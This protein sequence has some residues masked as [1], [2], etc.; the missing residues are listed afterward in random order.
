M[1]TKIRLMQIV[2][3]F[4]L[5]ALMLNVG[6]P[7]MA[8]HGHFDLSNNEFYPYLKLSF[9]LLIESIVLM[10]LTLLLNTNIP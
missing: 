3:A 8:N 4:L 5:F 10:I 9:F 6:V 2:M 1:L 7:L